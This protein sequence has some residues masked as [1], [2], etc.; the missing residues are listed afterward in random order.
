MRKSYLLMILPLLVLVLA[1]TSYGW[2]G[3]MGGMGDPYGLIADES[4]FLIHPAKISKGEGVRF[5]GDYRFTY[6]GVMDWKYN[7][8]EFALMANA[9]GFKVERVWCDERLWF[10]VLYLVVAA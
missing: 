6:T 4:D 7:L 8:D 5:Y 3:R 9:A 2:Q 10:S 1:N